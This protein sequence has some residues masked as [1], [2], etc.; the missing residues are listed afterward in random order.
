[1]VVAHGLNYFPHQSVSGCGSCTTQS[2]T[3]SKF[4]GIGFH[5]T[6]IRHV[7]YSHVWL[8]L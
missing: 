2:E 7:A 1:M 6:V 5:S 8:F 4:D 3:S